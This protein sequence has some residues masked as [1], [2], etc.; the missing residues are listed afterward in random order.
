MFTS[1]FPVK[2]DVEI[3][4]FPALQGPT[5]NALAAGVA[6]TLVLINIPGPWNFYFVLVNLNSSIIDLLSSICAVQL[7]SISIDLPINSI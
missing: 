6:F 4:H 3:E 1:Y 5:L 7:S 2:L